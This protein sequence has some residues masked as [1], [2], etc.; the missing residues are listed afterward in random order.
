MRVKIRQPVWE[1]A[2]YLHPQ[3]KKSMD[4]R[5]FVNTATATGHHLLTL[6]N[7]HVIKFQNSESKCKHQEEIPNTLIPNSKLAG[8]H[9][10]LIISVTE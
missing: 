9:S 4:A 7:S 6:T 2:P 8:S 10:T 1:N 3:N 5:G